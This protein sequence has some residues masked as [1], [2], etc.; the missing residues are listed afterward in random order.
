MWK[1]GQKHFRY[2]ENDKSTDLSS[3]MRRN[4]ENHVFIHHNQIAEILWTW[5]MY[6]DN[7]TAAR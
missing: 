2:D 6:G 4:E 3:S 7:L 5:N 1:N